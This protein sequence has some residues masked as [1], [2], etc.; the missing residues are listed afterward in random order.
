MARAAQHNSLNQIRLAILD[1]DPMGLFDLGMGGLEEY[2]EFIVPITKAMK[3]SD[4]VDELVTYLLEIVKK[5]DDAK[6]TPEETQ[7]IAE[8]MLKIKL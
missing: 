4:T 5:L 6:T 7:P 3:K 8:R 1:W 2:D